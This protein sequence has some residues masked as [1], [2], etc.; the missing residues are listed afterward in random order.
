MNKICFAVIALLS[1]ASA[2]NLNRELPAKNAGRNKLDL[3]EIY[4]VSEHD[5][6]QDEVAAAK[7]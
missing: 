3:D 5:N 7:K 4:S 2:T 6:L 1:L